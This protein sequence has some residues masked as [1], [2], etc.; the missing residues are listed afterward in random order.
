MDAFCEKIV[1]LP[2]GQLWRHNEGGDLPSSD[3]KHIDRVKVAKIVHANK[4]KKGFTYTHYNPADGDNASIIQEANH[5]G[6]T[7]NL[8]ADNLAEAD[9][10]KKLNVGPVVVVLPRDQHT[11]LK[12][13]E[14]NQVV[15]CPFDTKGIQ[16]N[17]CKLCAWRDRKVIIGFPAHGSS[18]K[19]AELVAIQSVS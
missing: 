12:T 4:G 9:Q 13:P 14:G 10:F 16:C 8:S 15:I 1:A 7:V 6:F 17:D 11:N 2:D 19:K 3:R 18:A 5:G